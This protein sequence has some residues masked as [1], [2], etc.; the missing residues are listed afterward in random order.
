MTK[1]AINGFGRIGRLLSRELM[2]KAGKGTQMRLR[3][4][5]T[6]GEID[7]TVLEKRASLLKM[8]SVHG[9]FNGTVAIDEKNKALIIMVLPYTSYQPMHQKI[10]I[11]QNTE[12]I[13]LW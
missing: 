6:R 11:I 3:A 8:D 5:V 2:N 12:L 9:D 13:M 4:I 10:S 7:K 1:V